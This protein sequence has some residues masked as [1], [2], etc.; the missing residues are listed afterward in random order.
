MAQ[1]YEAHE[2]FSG[3]IRMYAHMFR[4]ALAVGLVIQ[5][6]FLAW[7][8]YRLYPLVISQQSIA[9]DQM[10]M[11]VTW[12]YFTG[13]SI[14]DDDLLVEPELA[15]F[16]EGWQTLDWRS[17]R[18]VANRATGGWYA[19]LG[20]EASRIL[21]RSLAA[22]GVSVLYVLVFVAW[23]QQRRDET[24]LRGV[25]TTPLRELNRKLRAAAGDG[26]GLQI[27]ETLI[28][29]DMEI[30]HLLILGASGSGKSTL[31][32]QLMA[33]LI[34]RRERCVI[35]DPKG[36]FVSK[37]YKRGDTVFNLLDDRSVGWNVFNEIFSEPDYDVIATSLF[38]PPVTGD[39]YWY[40]CAGDVFRTGLVWLRIHGK[41]SNDA[42]WEFF[43]Q[44]L[45]G[46]QQAFHMLPIAE[47]G[48]L[49]H[50]D[51]SD[52]PASASIISILQERIK[53]FRYLRG[54]D[55]DFSFSKYIRA[56]AGKGNIFLLG[57]ERTKE[58]M[59][60]LLTLVMDLMCRETLSLPDN[61]NRRIFFVIDELAT[62]NR[63]DSILTLE[64]VGR[65]KGVALICANQDL[66]RIEEIYGRNNLKTFYNNFNTGVIFRIREPE[67]AEFLSRAIGEQQLRKRSESTQMSPS[68]VGDRRGISEQ[69]RT[70]R[71]IMPTELQELPDLCAVLNVAGFGVSQITIPREFYP[72]R[73]QAFVARDFPDFATVSMP[74]AEPPI[75]VAEKLRI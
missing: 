28:P 9:G 27:G 51:Q 11:V 16:A 52:S 8:G 3:H 61:P 21:W 74:A 65:S 20:A 18:I 33:Q 64:T 12:K 7:H 49:K 42:I 29:R 24:F 43:S 71:L 55:G 13:L 57:N 23:S 10:S 2:S 73:H 63:M 59:Q 40:N 6:L 31:L 66:G 75:D 70:E 67:T 32:N 50:I 35:Y 22:Y 44:P 15:P 19:A 25:R 68:D 1:G 26:G 17:Y 37:L 60:P 34:R 69:E 36:E 5:L 56:E 47:Q 54:R 72:V 41:T 30:K 48:A 58:L 62:L 4:R 45:A 38:T 46:I 39:S 53:V 14:E